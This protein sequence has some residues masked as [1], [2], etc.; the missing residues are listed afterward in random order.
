MLVDALSARVCYGDGKRV[1]AGA[2]G[3]ARN[4]SGTLELDQ[5]LA[6]RLR[7]DAQARAHVA[8]WHVAALRQNG[9]HAPLARDG[10]GRD[11]AGLAPQRVMPLLNGALKLGELKKQLLTACLLVAL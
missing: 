4:V 11:I 1:G 6:K 3:F 2:R 8:L 5:H 10:I 9:Q 7:R